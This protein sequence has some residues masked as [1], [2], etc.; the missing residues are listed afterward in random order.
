M[1]ELSWSVGLGP[2]R[3]KNGKKRKKMIRGCLG[4][5]DERQRGAAAAQGVERKKK[6][7]DGCVWGF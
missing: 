4:V 3:E 7:G 1:R 5:R 6:I 2:V